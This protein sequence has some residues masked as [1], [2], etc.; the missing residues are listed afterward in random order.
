M[1]SRL[2][3]VPSSLSRCRGAKGGRG[4]EG[5]GLR[6]PASGGTPGGCVRLYDLDF[7]IRGGDA[8]TGEVA[9]LRR[10]SEVVQDALI[11]QVEV[12]YS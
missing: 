9:M 11:D 3:V 6:G 2:N 10:A 4:L 5:G 1:S 8:A 12:D 7:E